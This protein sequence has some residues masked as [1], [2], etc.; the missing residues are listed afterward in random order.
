MRQTSEVAAGGTIPSKSKDP[1]IYTLNIANQHAVISMK[2]L[3]I[4]TRPVSSYFSL[5]IK[6]SEL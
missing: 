6:S 5:N 3:L 2:T 1:P 4:L